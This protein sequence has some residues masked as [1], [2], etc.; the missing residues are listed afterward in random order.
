MSELIRPRH[1][2]VFEALSALHADAL[3]QTECYFGGGT[4]IAMTLDEYRE[5]ADIVFCVQAGQAIVRYVRR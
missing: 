4:R 5:S 1:K 3:V 2:L